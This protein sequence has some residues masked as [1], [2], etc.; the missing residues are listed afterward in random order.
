MR[1]LYFLA[2]RLSIGISK[3][4]AL[5]LVSSD[6]VAVDLADRV[7][8]AWW[9]LPRTGRRGNPPGW[10]SLEDAH[11]I[12]QGTISRIVSG[13]RRTVTTDVAE[14][15]A[16]ALRCS[17]AWL[18]AG[19]G[20]APTS[21]FIIP[22]RPEPRSEVQHESPASSVAPPLI[23]GPRATATSHRAVACAFARAM[24]LPEAAVVYCESMPDHPYT[25]DEWLCEIKLAAANQRI[26]RRKFD[27]VA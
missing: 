14:R 22:P 2:S 20:D 1:Q 19:D 23:S 17:V 11:G 8:L 27:F 25:A 9:C 16:R 18:V 13:E 4:V 6:F 10:K 21:S 3:K 24:G 12:S 26:G 5:V 15:L 7:W